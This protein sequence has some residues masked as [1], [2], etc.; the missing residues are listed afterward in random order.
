[1][2]SKSV[3][4]HCGNNT[5]CRL[6]TLQKAALCSPLPFN[7]FLVVI[8]LHLHFFFQLQDHV[9]QELPA[10]QLGLGHLGRAAGGTG[11]VLWLLPGTGAG[12]EF[13]FGA[14]AGGAGA[15]AFPTFSLGGGNIIIVRSPVE[16]E[17]LKKIMRQCSLVSIGNHRAHAAPRSIFPKVTGK[18]VTFVTAAFLPGWSSCQERFPVR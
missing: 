18:Y 2:G 16:V 7:L 4:H 14:A 13:L 15:A 17:Q 3:Q 1:M 11:R 6:L 5:S 9:L 12:Q 10:L 8:F